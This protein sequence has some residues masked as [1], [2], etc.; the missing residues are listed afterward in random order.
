MKIEPNSVQIE[1]V[2]VNFPKV[3]AV[4]S[5]NPVDGTWYISVNDVPLRN[6]RLADGCMYH[7]D[8]SIRKFQTIDEVF[9]FLKEKGLIAFDIKIKEWKKSAK[10]TAE[11]RMVGQL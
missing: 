7:K 10:I 11:I 8:T 1:N 2:K 6:D 5:T 9:E 3:E 4:P